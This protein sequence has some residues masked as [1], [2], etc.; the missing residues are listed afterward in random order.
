MPGFVPYG[1]SLAWTGG[2]DSEAENEQARIDQIGLPDSL[3]V[4]ALALLGVRSECFGQQVK[5]ASWRETAEHKPQLS[6]SFF[7]GHR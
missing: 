3:G 2:V 5:N 6:L 4:V 1:M 7:F